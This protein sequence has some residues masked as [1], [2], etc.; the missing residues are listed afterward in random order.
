[1]RLLKIE[2]RGVTRFAGTVAVNFEELGPGLI[3]LVGGNGAGKSTIMEAPAAALWKA[4]PSRPGFYENFSGSDAFI[5]ATFDGGTVRLNVDAV[6]KT[7]EGYVIVN[8]EP[9]T[10]GKAASFAAAVAERFGSFDLFLASVFA[11]QSKRGSFLGL[12]K[13]ARKDRFVELLGLGVLQALSEAARLRA[14]QSGAELTAA[15]SS[16]ATIATQVE[17]FADARA[18]LDEKAAATRAV[19]EQLEAARTAEAAA[20][21]SLEDSKARCSR[22]DELVARERA[23]RATRVNADKAT[24][25]AAARIE[26]AGRNKAERIRLVEQRHADELET[27]ANLRYE[28]GSGRIAGQRARLTET[29]LGLPDG[30]AAE[31]RRVAL[32][33]QRDEAR[34][35][36]ERVAAVHRAHTAADTAMRSERRLL[37]GREAARAQ[38]VAQLEQ[39]GRRLGEV[40]C[41]ASETWTGDALP[42]NLIS[43]ASVR[44][45]GMCP[46]LADARGAREELA[47]LPPVDRTE[48]ETAV[49]VHEAA[50]AA[51]EL[52][53]PA[54]LDP[55]SYDRE[56]EAAAADVA[57]AA[58]AGALQE[59]LDAL[60]G[61]AEILAR[62]LD[63][64]VT[65]ARA[66]VA[67]AARELV[68]IEAEYETE[69]AEAAQALEAA[70]AAAETAVAQHDEAAAEL[71]AA[72]GVDLEHARGQLEQSKRIRETLEFQQREADKALAA[73]QAAADR[74]AELEAQHAP[75]A[76]A[77]AKAE[78]EVGDWGLLERSLGRDGVQALEIDA[79]GPEVATITN[80]LLASCYGARFSLTLETLAEKRDG[81]TREVF[82]VRVYDGGAERSVEAYSGG[83]KVVIG[84]ALGLALAIVNARK[85][86]V[87]WE[88]F[89]RD[90]TAG[91]L[92]PDNAVAYV[93]MMRRAREL[94][95]AHQIVFVAHQPEV[96]EAA[97]AVVMIA[98]GKAVVRTSEVPA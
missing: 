79:A 30:P 43:G 17:R 11:C 96:W 48:Y 80:E 25:A 81:G 55:A 90:E 23:A 21:G 47:K 6:K 88:T 24:A 71:D 65:A 28:S 5:E 12:A 35:E 75:V 50:K 72:E 85:S 62:E 36:A 53:P 51:A 98:D 40:P 92:D 31:A 38:R 69:S 9:T 52:L 70:Q 26:G 8:G 44:L 68:G 46:L 39:Q 91:A 87:R 63:A 93:R 59:Q 18:N 13:G 66:A 61:E 82:D 89:F 78:T 33:Q 37:D 41:T 20:L 74:L 45:A 76:A 29:L 64:E 49:R 73:A 54:V 77:V 67:A 60:G 94:A 3:A 10:D 84:E 7:T 15:R 22:M 58:G 57:K 4:F 27:A 97:D 56:I 95:G 42:A 14:G 32:V 19:A 83:E 16:L 2:L 86:G 34:A 1:M